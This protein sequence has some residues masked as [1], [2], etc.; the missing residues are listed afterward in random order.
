MSNVP[1]TDKFIARFWSAVDKSPNGT[2]ATNGL[3]TDCWLWKRST[4]GKYGMQ[5]V[6]KVFC[7]AHRVAYRIS[8]PDEEIDGWIVMHKCDNPPCCR[9]DHLKRGTDADNVRDA[10]LKGRRKSVANSR[11]I[12]RSFEQRRLRYG[13]VR[14]SPEAVADIQANYR[15]GKGGTVRML[16]KKWGVSITHIRNIG[17]GKFHK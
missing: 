17:K 8:H 3:G 13:T 16:S 15:P 14:V 1:Y 6:G 7:S 11:A 12:I 4:N 2:G 9:P 5:R 10:D